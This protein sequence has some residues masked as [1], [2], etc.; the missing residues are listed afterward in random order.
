MT[1]TDVDTINSVQDKI[2]LFESI[3]LNEEQV[4]CPLQHFFT[5]GLYTRQIFIPKGTYLTSKVHKT[6]HPYIISVGEISVFIEDEGEVLLKAPHMGIT[7][8]GTRRVLFAHTDVVWTTF[9]A[10]DK[11]TVEEVEK[12]IIFDYQNKLLPNKVKEVK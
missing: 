7:L 6:A 3:L 4:N 12:D 9:H 10:T 8:P 1:E 5:P 2:D 11:E